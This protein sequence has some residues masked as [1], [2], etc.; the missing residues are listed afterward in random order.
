MKGYSSLLV[1][2]IAT[3]AMVLWHLFVSEQQEERI[4]YFDT[5]L[6]ALDLPEFRSSSLRDLERMRH[7]VGWCSNVEDLCGQ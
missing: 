4:S 2:T 3:S 5:R 7:I 1:A 6:D